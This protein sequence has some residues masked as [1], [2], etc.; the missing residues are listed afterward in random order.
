MAINVAFDRGDSLPRSSPL[1]SSLVKLLVES[2]GAAE[3]C[4]AEEFAGAVVCDAS[5]DDP[6]GV[7]GKGWAPLGCEV[8]FEVDGDFEEVDDEVGVFVVGDVHAPVAHDVGD[9]AA[10][11][12]F[13]VPDVLVVVLGAAEAVALRCAVGPAFDAERELRREDAWSHRPAV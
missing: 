8:A 13:A 9:D 6:S 2:F 3:S 4:A 11:E 10:D 12:R 1:R 7:A 5:A